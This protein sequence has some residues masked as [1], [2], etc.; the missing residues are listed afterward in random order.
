MAPQIGVRKCFMILSINLI[1]ILF[2]AS[3]DYI[4]I[5]YRMQMYRLGA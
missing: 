3:V 4:N 1:K 5:E 2:A